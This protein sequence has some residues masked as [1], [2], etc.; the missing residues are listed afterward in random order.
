M[1]ALLTICVVISIAGCSGSSGN[2]KGFLADTEGDWYAYGNSSGEIVLNEFYYEY[3]EDGEVIL[4][5]LYFHDDGTVD[6]DYPGETV[7]GC[8]GGGAVAVL[9][10]KINQAKLV[11]LRHLRFPL[12][13]YS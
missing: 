3:G 7:Y 12:S 1:T 2:L 11:Q 13:M 5:S 8:I 9:P 10:D 4:G 6:V